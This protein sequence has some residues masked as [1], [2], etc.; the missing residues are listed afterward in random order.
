[1]GL[2]YLTIT[3][4]TDCRC[5]QSRVQQSLSTYLEMIRS[6]P[7]DNIRVRQRPNRRL[8][9]HCV[10]VALRTI[11]SQETWLGP[12]PFGPS[13]TPA[14]R[15]R[16]CK[17]RVE[18]QRGPARGTTRAAWWPSAPLHS[19]VARIAFERQVLSSRGGGWNRSQ[20]R[21]QT[22]RAIRCVKEGRQPRRDFHYVSF[23]FARLRSYGT[24]LVIHQTRREHSVVCL[25]C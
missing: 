10:T 24:H 22:V 15:R 9:G 11:T 25:W 3:T 20:A 16:A 18:G 4:R 12:C 2:R 7:N 6:K 23:V 21:S 8:Q 13:R 19:C 14:R 5:Q 1:M 17:I